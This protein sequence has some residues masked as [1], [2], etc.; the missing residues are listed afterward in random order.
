MPGRLQGTLLTYPIGYYSAAVQGTVLG[1]TVD[2]SALS[3]LLHP[4]P[5]P[6]RAD[7]LGRLVPVGSDCVSRGRAVSRG[8]VYPWSETRVRVRS[9]VWLGLLVREAGW[10][11]KRA[12]VLPLRGLPVGDWIALLAYRLGIWAGPGVV[13]RSQR[14]LLVRAFAG[15]SIHKGPRVYEPDTNY[16]N[17]V[18]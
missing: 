17:Y 1:I 7:V 4:F 16:T 3:Y 6:Y 15:K 5:G 14:R 10:S 11:R 2:L 9:G 8:L 18:P 13:R 12:F